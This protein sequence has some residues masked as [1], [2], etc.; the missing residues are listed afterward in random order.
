[1]LSR[2]NLLQLMGMGAAPSLLQPR[3]AFANTAPKRCIILFTQHGPWYDGWKM[4]QGN[5]PEDQ[6]WTFS[7]PNVQTEF[8]QSLHF[9]SMHYD[10]GGGDRSYLYRLVMWVR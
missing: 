7:L 2:R 9:R 4:R 8:S 6:H 5:R 10:G 3:T 1:M